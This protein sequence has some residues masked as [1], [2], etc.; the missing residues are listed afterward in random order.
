MAEGG[1]GGGGEGEGGGA[2][3]LAYMTLNSESG[4]EDHI[5]C[6]LIRPHRERERK[7]THLAEGE[8]EQYSLQS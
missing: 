3:F 5:L 6:Q 1:G 7:W 4:N 2:A 8:R